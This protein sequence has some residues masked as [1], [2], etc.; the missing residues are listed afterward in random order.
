[1]KAS[2]QQLTLAEQEWL[3]F[4]DFEDKPCIE[5]DG[6]TY[7]YD[8]LTDLFE[9]FPTLFQLELDKTAQVVN[10]LASGL[11]YQFIENSDQFKEEFLQR[12]EGDKRYNYGL[13]DVSKMHSPIIR[14]S[15]FIF[16]VMEERTQLP[17]RVSM[18][19][20]YIEGISSIRYELL[21]YVNSGMKKQREKV[22][23]S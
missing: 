1:M 5:V 15:H 16:F 9:S 12:L 17:Y 11:E 19:L 2:I 22:K 10:F 18:D 3:F 20:P 13:F 23:L 14:N 6:I 8:L 7:T 21:P 4:F